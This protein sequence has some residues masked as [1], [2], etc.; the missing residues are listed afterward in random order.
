MVQDSGITDYWDTVA[1]TF[2]EEPDHGLG[3]PEVRA[4]WAARMRGWL[5]GG[6]CDVLDLGCGTGSLAL[7]AAEQGHRVTAVDRSARM[8]ERA[9]AKLAGTGARVLVGEAAEPPVGGQFDVVLV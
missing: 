5:P 3:S 2:D 6:P 4:A 9:R 7:L 8:V 1:D